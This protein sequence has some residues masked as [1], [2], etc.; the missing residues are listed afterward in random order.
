MELKK[1]N[2]NSL[3]NVY[4][5]QELSSMN[6]ILRKAGPLE[7]RQ[8]YKNSFKFS[9]KIKKILQKTLKPVRFQSHEAG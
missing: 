2:K 1:I 3:K 5:Q 9:L 8:R 7:L 4:Q 6:K